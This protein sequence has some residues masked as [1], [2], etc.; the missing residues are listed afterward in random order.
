MEPAVSAPRSPPAVT[1]V[2]GLLG[3]VPFVGCAAASLLTTGVFRALFQV[4]ALVYG[5]L[6]LSFLGGGRW[7][8]EIGRGPVRAG[9][10]SGS[11]IGAIF[12]TLLTAAAGV[13]TP[14][15][16]VLMALA[17]LGQWAWDVRSA[18]AP[19]WYPQLRHV[20]TAGAV[21]SLLVAA[22]ASLR[23]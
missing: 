5:G 22:G 19:P 20:L 15:R 18:D 9:V 13:S 3:L 11:M 2:Y 7:G 1:W 4:V 16:L 10:I 8:L 17:H 6:I 23:P 14:L 21:L 12:A